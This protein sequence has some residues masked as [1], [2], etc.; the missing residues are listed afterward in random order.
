MRVIPLHNRFASD[1][2]SIITP[3]LENSERIIANRSSLIIKASPARQIELL[4]LIKQLDQRLSNLTITVIQSKTDTAHSLNAAARVRVNL[5]P[6]RSANLSAKMHARFADTTSLNQSDSQQKIQTLDGKPAYI[7]T[8]KIYPVKDINLFHSSDGQP[9]IS[10]NTRLISATTGFLVTPRLS[11]KQV[12]LEITPW[13]DKMNNNGS[14][15][16]QGAHSTVQ[17]NLG[18]WI[19][20]GGIDQQSQFSS[21][22]TLSHAYSTKN[23]SMKILI[24]VDKN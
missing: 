15:S 7:K 10:S 5:S 17:V 24:K 21:H 14:L 3:L 23:N 4:N 8:G 12:N 16:T 20:I 19:E 13:S 22:A 2:H 6:H 9:I 18:V 1:L 11:G